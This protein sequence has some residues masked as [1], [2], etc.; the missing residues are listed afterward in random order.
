MINTRPLVETDRRY[1]QREAAEALQ[2]DRHTIRRYEEAGCIKFAIRK[3]GR[4]KFTTGSQIIRC[5]E[6]CYL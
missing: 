2:V 5:W 6:A 4:A 3:A 1:N